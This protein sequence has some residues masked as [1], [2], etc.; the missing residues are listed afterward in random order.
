MK[1]YLGF[2]FACLVGAPHLGAER[3]FP[4]APMYT[5]YMQSIQDDYA[6][7]IVRCKGFDTAIELD[8]KD[9]ILQH[10]ET[11]YRLR[12]LQIMSDF[13][14]DTL[15]KVSFLVSDEQPLQR[16]QEL[17]DWCSQWIEFIESAV[18]SLK[19]GDAVVLNHEHG[20]SEYQT[21]ATC[22][23]RNNRMFGAY[24]ERGEK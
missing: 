18:E 13:Y 12:Q 2:V 7:L 4:S 21:R 17:V 3:I 1:V 10:T 23:R 6:S 9:G 15:A 24:P 11:S 20:D 19:R 5:Y 8:K 22:I 14:K 16:E